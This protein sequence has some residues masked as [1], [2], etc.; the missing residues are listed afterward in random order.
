MVAVE[1]GNLQGYVCAVTLT[2]IH[3]LETKTIGEKAARMAIGQLLKLYEV[4]PVTRIVI[5]EALDSSLNDFEDAV[6]AQAALHVA[7]FGIVTRN[8]KGFE[9]APLAI[10]SPAALLASL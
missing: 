8:S 6:L 10:Y 1:L 4:A 7:A 5:S 3:Y 9:N 2:T